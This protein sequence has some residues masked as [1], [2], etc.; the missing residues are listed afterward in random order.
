[1]ARSNAFESQA[2]VWGPVL[3]LQ[4]HLE[5]TPNWVQWIA[6]RD[7]GTLPDSEFVQSLE[8]ILGKPEKLYRANNATMKQ[9]L[10]RWLEHSSP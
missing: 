3:A 1:M 4:F 8:T 2:F 9:L 7:A 10:N 5:V 6:T